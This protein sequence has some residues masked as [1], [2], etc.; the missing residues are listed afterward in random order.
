MNRWVDISAIVA[1]TAALWALGFAWVT[2]VMSVRQQSTEEFQAIKSIV[3]GLRIELEFMKGWTGFGGEGYSK[4]IAKD[5]AQPDWS[6]PG[7]LIWKFD[8]AAISSLTR[9]PFLYRLSSIVEPFARLNFSVSR[10]FQLYDE[11]RNFVNSDPTVFLYSEESREHKQQVLNFNYIMHV[12][13][14]GGADSDD[15]SCLFKAYG[16]AKS[17]LDNFDAV[18]EN[19]TLPKWF[20]VG[21]FVSAACFVSGGFLLYR[22]FRA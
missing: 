13:L 22:M 2:Y 3:N 18:L 20:W 8:T 11:Y 5:K 10:L 6:Q 16:A 4:T 7:R 1:A 9:S 14:I 17:A 12:N 15:E 21:H 19:E